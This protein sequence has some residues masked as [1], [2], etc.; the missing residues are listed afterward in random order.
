M[1]RLSVK[2][3]KKLHEELLRETGGSDG[4]RDESL[5][6]SALNSPFA[7]FGGEYL[8]RSIELQAARLAFSL[9]KN[10]PFVDGNKRVGIMVMLIFLELN[11][12]ALSVNDEQLIEVGLSLADG[13]MTDRQLAA[14]ILTHST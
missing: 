7:S 10:H 4:L 8:Y 6:E 12:I 3:V 9:V 5:L 1:K 2:Q 11:G 13:T 14:W